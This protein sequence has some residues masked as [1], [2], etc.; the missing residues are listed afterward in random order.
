MVHVIVT[1]ALAGGILFSGKSIS[2]YFTIRSGYR[3]EKFVPPKDV[4]TPFLFY[5]S[6]TPEQ[7][8]HVLRAG[9]SALVPTC[10]CLVSVGVNRS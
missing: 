1:L 8:F 5:L 3:N 9:R 2:Q 7:A 4:R 10:L 6:D